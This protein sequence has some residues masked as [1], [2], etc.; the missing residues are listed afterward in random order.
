MMMDFSHAVL[1]NMHRN[2]IKKITK[3]LASIL[4]KN[5]S[6]CPMTVLLYFY[7]I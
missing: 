1:C 3:A 4:L 7:I 2:K 6:F 5:I